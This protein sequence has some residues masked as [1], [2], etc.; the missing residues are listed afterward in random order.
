MITPAEKDF[1]LENAYLPEHLPDY[2]SG[3]SGGEPFLAADFV[4]YL[5]PASLVFVGFPLRGKFEEK[6]MAKTLEGVIRQRSPARITIVAPSIP[7]RFGPAG[8]ADSYYRLDLEGFRMP[9]KVR[10]MVQRASRELQVRK[11]RELES[12]HLHLI[13]EFSRTRPLE[14]GTRTIFARIPEYLSASSTAWVFSARTGRGDLAAFD[15]ADFAP[16]RYAFYMFNF[17]SREKTVPGTSDLLL[18]EIVRA[19]QEQG[20]G[21]INLGLGISPGV[22][23]FKKKWGGRPFLEHSSVSYQPSPTAPLEG[24]LSKL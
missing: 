18:T 6:K 23:F 24:L 4:F 21:A 17:R 14:E 13:S 11:G 3:V 9:A 7:V 15:I 12:D 5:L 22:A 2:A 10:N 1:I 8:L 19:A 20:K 16:S